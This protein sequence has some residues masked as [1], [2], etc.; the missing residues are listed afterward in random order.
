VGVAGFG[1]GG[2]GVLELVLQL[3]LQEGLREGLLLLQDMLLLCCLLLHN[4]L[5]THA[6]IGMH[7]FGALSE[8]EGAVQ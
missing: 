8:W 3:L 4:L 5:R 1:G 2:E 7:T 6:P